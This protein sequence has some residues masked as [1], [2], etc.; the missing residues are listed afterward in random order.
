MERLLRT[1]LLGLAN[2]SVYALAA[3]GVVLIYKTTRILNLGYGALALFTTFIYWQF[4]VNWGWPLGISALLVVVVIAP[5]IGFFLDSQLFRR[6]E[7]QPLV[8]GV[9][10]T[11]GLT[12]LL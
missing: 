12:V 4:T 9:I 1:V 8:I 10:A 3:T 7:G 11:V 2:G 6:I 5:A